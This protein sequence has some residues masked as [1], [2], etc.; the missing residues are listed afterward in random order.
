MQ[1]KIPLIRNSLASGFG[2]LST[3]LFRF[4]Q[5]PLLLSALGAEE[6][7]RWLVLYSFP[8]WLA[9]ANLG[10]GSVAANE[11]AMAVAAEDDEK[12]RGV[13][14][15]VLAL[16]GGILV[17]GSAITAVIAPFVPWEVLFQTSA[18]QHN[19]LTLAVIWFTISTL[20]SFLVDAYA[21]RFRAARKAHLGIVLSTFRPWL[22]L[23]SVL[24]TL[25][26][27]KRFDYLALAI[28]G[29][30]VVY[31]LVVKWYSWRAWPTLVFN[32]A[33]VGAAH[34][35]L[36]VRKG[37]SFQAFPLGNALLFQ[38][39]LLLVQLILGP[40]AVAI[41]GTVRTLVRSI[42]QLL[43]MVNQILWPELSVL[44][45]AGKLLQVARLH[46]IGV[47]VSILVAGLSVGLLALFGNALY[48][49]WTGNAIPMPQRLLLLFLLPI[50]FNALWFTSSVTHMAS[51][52]H[53]PLAVRYLIAA[54]LSALACALLSY[55]FGIE[56]AAV[57]TLVGDIVL[58]PYVFKTSLILTGDTWAGFMTGLR[59]EANALILM[60][61][62]AMPGSV[63]KSV[64][65]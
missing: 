32:R 23:L 43:E 49:L 56:G 46:R 45:G 2:K 38:G 58:I 31:L 26:F 6:Y 33:L 65:K 18:A 3:V 15:T 48:E 16:L 59:T 34:Y 5:V 30:T 27:T 29:S 52:Q 55:G 54:G 61:R 41:F 64:P 47:A 25:Q 24:V 39:N 50:P 36:L 4:V 21:A 8:S 28:L 11:I 1:L 53:G 57:S 22:E 37:L 44:F 13:F 7:G 9:L 51:N 35:R 60:T 12:A 63:P 42:N 20:L 62:K 10:F 17:V 40:T 14:A 19:Q